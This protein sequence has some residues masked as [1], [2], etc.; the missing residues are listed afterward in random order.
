MKNDLNIKNGNYITLYKVIDGKLTACRLT[1]PR[2][3][4]PFGSVMQLC[5]D[6]EYRADGSK[7]EKINL[8]GITKYYLSIEEYKAN[9]SSHVKEIIYEHLSLTVTDVVNLLDY[10]KSEYGIR[11][12]SGSSGFIVFKWSEKELR[13]TAKSFHIDEINIVTGICYYNERLSATEYSKLPICNINETECLID[14][15]ALGW[16]KTQEDCR[17]TNHIDIVDFAD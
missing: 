3:I 9:H 11:S 6:C 15:E 13:P 2:W 14:W 10:I 5:C 1:N 12:G 16:Y 17:A 8:C 7:V 4:C